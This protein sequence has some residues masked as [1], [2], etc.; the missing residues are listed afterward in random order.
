[1]N[2]EQST[3]QLQY[4]TD[5]YDPIRW[6]HFHQSHNLPAFDELWIMQ[7]QPSLKK[8]RLQ[9]TICSSSTTQQK[10]EK[11]GEIRYF[12]NFNSLFWVFANKGWNSSMYMQEICNHISTNTPLPAL[13]LSDS[14]TFNYSLSCRRTNRR[15]L[16][17]PPVHSCLYSSN[18]VAL[19][20][21]YQ[22]QWE[23]IKW[24]PVSVDK[25]MHIRHRLAS[26]GLTLSNDQW[27]SCIMW[28]SLN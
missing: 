25:I 2:Y 24:Q 1:M 11:S 22:R 28:G 14:V 19:G 12:K 13:V 23:H 4:Q 8:P 17:Q 26:A 3:L 7:L 27:H 20:T 15:P 10:H 9:T 21:K 16:S 6:Q 5:E 18:E